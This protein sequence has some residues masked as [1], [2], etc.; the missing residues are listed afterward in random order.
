[1]VKAQ[2]AKNNSIADS[3]QHYRK[4]LNNGLY[5]A[6][7]NAQ[8]PLEAFQA[9]VKEMLERGI[10]AHDVGHGDL[11]ERF[12]AESLGARLVG[13][14]VVKARTLALAHRALHAAPAATQR[15]G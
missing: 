12:A 9:R 2:F 3:F 1:M 15:H 6:V 8:N 4:T 10:V 14:N 11:A 5:G 13:E 7:L